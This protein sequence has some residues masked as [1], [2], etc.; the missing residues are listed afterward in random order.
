VRDDQPK[1]DLVDRR[2]ARTESSPLVGC[3]RHDPT[4]AFQSSPDSVISEHDDA[5]RKKEKT[6]E[7][8]RFSSCLALD[9]GAY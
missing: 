3:L 4:P 6:D 2:A 9:L 5:R 7:V 1:P 8:R